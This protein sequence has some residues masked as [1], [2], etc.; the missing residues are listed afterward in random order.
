MGGGRHFVLEWSAG[1]VWQC[2]KGVRVLKLAGC[3]WSFDPRASLISMHVMVQKTVGCYVINGFSCHLSLWSFWSLRLTCCTC[4]LVLMLAACPWFFDP[5]ARFISM[6]VMTK[7]TVEMVW[8]M[9]FH[10]T[11]HLWCSLM[12]KK[13]VICLS[14]FFWITV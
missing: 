10:V 8:L 4:L 7:K 12:F 5:R 1:R 14:C 11:C 6:H 2:A 9:G 13:N 3:P